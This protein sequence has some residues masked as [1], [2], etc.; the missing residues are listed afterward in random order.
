MR[1]PDSFS[2]P[3]RAMRFAATMLSVAATLFTGCAP[4]VKVEGARHAEP[5]RKQ[6][7][8]RLLVV[9]VSHDFNQ[10][11][12][13]EYSMV[14]QLR[15]ETMD[16]AAS[17]DSMNSKEQLSRESIERLVASLKPDS[18]LAT[19]LVG[20][21][22]SVQEGGGMDTRGGAYYKATDIG[23]APSYYGAWGM[24]VVYAEFETAPPITT[25]KGEVH[26][27]SRLYDARDATLIYSVDTT[28]RDLD[29]PQSALATITPPI[30]ERLRKEG[31]IH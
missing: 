11:C 31:L 4:Q 5:A 2:E 23:F 1:S 8:A 21:N 27:H 28:A 9:G 18:V 20:K 22:Y 25:L 13:F 29:S 14:T 17:C 24:P 30:A 16:A 3:S 7:F 26:V 12:A 15:T 19:L 10:R 6:A